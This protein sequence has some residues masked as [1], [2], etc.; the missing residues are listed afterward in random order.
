MKIRVTQE[1]IERGQARNCRKC[2]VALALR[3][4]FSF[5]EVYGTRWYGGS[6]SLGHRIRDLPRVAAAFIARFDGHKCGDPQPF[7]FELE[8]AQ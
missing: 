7:E 5:A 6:E 3:K 8:L 2:P 1:D 4:H